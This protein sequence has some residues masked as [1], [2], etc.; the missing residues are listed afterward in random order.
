MRNGGQALFQTVGIKTVSILPLA[1]FNVPPL[2][3]QV[4]RFAV[5]HKLLGYPGIV[6]VSGGAD[7]VALIHALRA[8]ECDP[9]TVAHVNHQL[10][11]AESDADEIFVRELAE[12]LNCDC[13]VLVRN[14]AAE[15]D[16]LEAAA[17]RVRYEW[18]A[19]LAAEVGAKWIATGH[20]EDDQAE[21]V[22]H[23]LIRGT[24]QIGR[25]HV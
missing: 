2:P 1:R 21:T 19:A 7:S 15:P 24:G 14:V 5:A 6:A 25:A 20:T 16:N 9:L 12:N 13:R 18:F 17:R 8:A 23:R 4:R 10:R 3:E 11:G 22:L